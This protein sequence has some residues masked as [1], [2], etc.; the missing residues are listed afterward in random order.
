M[1]NPAT[2]VVEI[3]VNEEPADDGGEHR[4]DVANVVDFD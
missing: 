4:R 2:V 1:K 3:P